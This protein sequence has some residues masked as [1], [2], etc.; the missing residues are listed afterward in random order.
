LGYHGNLW[1]S[2]GISLKL[3]MFYLCSYEMVYKPGS[4][5]L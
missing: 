4:V 1:A 5:N 2:M 3:F